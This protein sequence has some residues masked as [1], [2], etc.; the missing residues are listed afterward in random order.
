M[1]I[2]RKD[3]DALNAQLYVQISSTDYAEKVEK[4]LKEYKRKANVPGFRPGMVPVG[5]L[6]K[7]YGKAI[8]AEEVNKIVSEALDNYIR[9]NNL[10]LLG[11]ILPNETNQEAINFDTDESFEFVF[12]FA[13]APEINLELSKNDSISYY[14][15]EI[16]GEMIN[17]HILSLQNN[18]GSNVDSEIVEEKD[19]ITGSLE[20]IS[21]ATEKYLVEEAKI[22]SAFLREEQKALFIGKK[23]GDV[24]TFNP[25]T[26]FVNEQDAATLLNVEKENIANF[27]SDFT[28]TIQKIS[29][30]QPHPLD[31]EFFDLVY[32]KDVVSSETE[33]REKEKESIQVIM[34][35]N[36]LY[37]FEDDA[38]AYVLNK[39]T[40]VVF[41]EAFLK[42][43]LLKTNKDITEEIIEKEFNGMLDVLKWQLFRNKLAVKNEIKVEQQ[44]LESYA[45]RMLKAQYA[46]YGITNFP[47]DLLA[48]YAKE[49][50]KKEGQAEKY[51]EAI[52]NEKVAA[53]IKEM[54]TLNVTPISFNDFQSLPRI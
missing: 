39:L 46:Q 9:E 50:L 49:T 27:A 6:K 4:T 54:V 12:D 25:L 18:F 35:E 26:A 38:R 5:L 36:S 24:I 15:I 31:Q 29:H 51:F 14:N 48:E 16:D 28:F 22:S 34:E 2:V 3:T 8:L 21:G 44:N 30:F 7:M 37:R 10:N 52:L 13:V 47:E 45:K 11:E 33:A 19:L 17:E 41:P 20:E 43:W 42:R 32:G 53:A 23:S 1:N 40:N